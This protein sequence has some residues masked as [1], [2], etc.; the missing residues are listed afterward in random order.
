MF[1]LYIQVKEVMSSLPEAKQL[2]TQSKSGAML[3]GLNGPGEARTLLW[4]K[5][6]HLPM[7]PAVSLRQSGWE[8]V[9]VPDSK[10]LELDVGFLSFPICWN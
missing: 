9:W 1:L 5:L 2:R 3:L 8:R 6:S 10:G 4:R 7:K